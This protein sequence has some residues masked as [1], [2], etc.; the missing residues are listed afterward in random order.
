MHSHVKHAGHVLIG[1][2]VPLKPHDVTDEAQ[3]EH[4]R[5]YPPGGEP[6]DRRGFRDHEALVPRIDY[7]PLEVVRPEYQPI[8]SADLLYPVSILDFLLL[9]LLLFYPFGEPNAAVW[10]FVE[11]DSND[12]RVN[13]VDPQRL[14]L[15]RN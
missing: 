3:E 6:E 9:A 8:G 7:L 4:D 12:V 13:I 11:P 2:R 5:S 14:G 10:L 1:E 15:S